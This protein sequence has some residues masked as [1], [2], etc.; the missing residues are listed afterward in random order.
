MAVNL[1]PAS[2][3]EDAKKMLEKKDLLEF[4]S[5]ISVAVEASRNNKEMLAKTTYL[6][7]KGLITF[8]QHSKA[9][10]CIDEALEY[11]I[12]VKAFELKKYKGVAKGFLGKANQALKILKE[13]TTETD[14]INLLVGVYINI[15]WVHLSLKNNNS[16]GRNIEEAKHYLDLANE[17]FDSL[18]NRRKWKVR[19]NYSVYYYYKD[20]FEKAIKIL[21]DSIKYCEEEELPDVYNNLAKLYIKISEDDSVSEVA[22]EYLKEAEALGTIYNKT[23]SLGYT[24]Y[25]KAEIE[26]IEDQT[27]FNALDALYISFEYFKK[28]EATVQACDTLLKINELMDEY[29]HNSLKSFRENLKNKLKNTPYYEKI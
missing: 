25:F 23:I 8:N 6:K 5:N 7:A 14:D 28:A 9:L 11:N 22:I 27:I 21:E 15:A 20:E 19:N 26:L 12:G 3:Y 18:S 10:S 29:K 4:V 17:H 16:D 13:L 1:A 2:F 24:F